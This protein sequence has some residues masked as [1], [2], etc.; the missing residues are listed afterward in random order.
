MITRKSFRD[1]LLL[2]MNRT[3]ET[4]VELARAL[5]AS[6]S[7]V[8]GWLTAEKFP[9][10]EMLNKI[11]EHF[12]VPVSSLLSDRTARTSVPVLGRVQAGTP[13]TAV[14]DLL[15]VVDISEHMAAQ[16]EHFGLY[17]RG[18]SM[19]PDFLEGDLVIV[20]RQ[21]S[22]DAGDIGV[23]SVGGDDATIK[24]FKRGK[25]G[26]VILLP[27]NP[28]FAPL[29]FSDADVQALPVLLLGKVVELRRAF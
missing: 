18:A 13:R 15:D 21:P 12:G 7:A 26:G 10:V 11:A 3:D 29:M 6:T 17:V 19:E 2:L 5:G 4:Q 28:D 20:R 27:H 24:E 9:R 22:L 14:Q 25:N 23:F 1:N 8:S 16:G